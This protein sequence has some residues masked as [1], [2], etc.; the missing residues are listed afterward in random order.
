MKLPLNIYFVS[1]VTDFEQIFVK[2]TLA[3]E[4]KSKLDC[5]LPSSNDEEDKE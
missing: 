2:D 4:T 3:V 1:Q 5:W